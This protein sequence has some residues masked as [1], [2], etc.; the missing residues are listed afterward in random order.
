MLRW[1]RRVVKKH[2]YGRGIVV[3]VLAGT[4]RPEKGCKEPAS[5]KDADEYQND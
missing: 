3:I 1:R 5:N 4:H 2:P